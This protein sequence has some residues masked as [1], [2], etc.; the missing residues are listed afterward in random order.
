[1]FLPSFF[2]KGLGLIKSPT[3]TSTHPNEAFRAPNQ[4][5]T[6]YV[7]ESDILY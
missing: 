2:N 6:I 3:R 7:V 5:Y 4:S 1:M